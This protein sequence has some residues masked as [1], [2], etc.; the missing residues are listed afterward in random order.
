MVCKVCEVKLTLKYVKLKKTK[1]YVSES[2]T[3]TL[4]K[5]LR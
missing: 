4:P 1:K 5:F 3:K 2:E